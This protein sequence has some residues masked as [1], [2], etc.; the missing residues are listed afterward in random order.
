LKQLRPEDLPSGVTASR[1]YDH[2][3]HCLI[4][5]HNALGELGKIVLITMHDNQMLL[6]AELYQGQAEVESPRVQ[7]KKHVFDQVVA[8]VNN[9]FNAHFSGETSP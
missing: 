1:G 6:Q 9:C 2:R 3:G 4:F 7:Q 5:A 8:T